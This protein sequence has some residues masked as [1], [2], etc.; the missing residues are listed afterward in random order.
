MWKIQT[1]GVFLNKKAELIHPITGEIDFLYP[2][3]ELLKQL[4][5]NTI[6]LSVSNIFNSKSNSAIINTPS[7]LTFDLDDLCKF[8]KNN[9]FN[10]RLSINMIATYDGYHYNDILNRCKGL[11]ADQIT[12]RKLYESNNNTPE[13]K[14]VRNNQCN[15]KTIYNIKESIKKYGKFLYKLPFGSNV[16]SIQGMSVAIDDDCMGKE[17]L[18]DDNS[19]KLKYVILREDGKLYCQWDDKGSLIF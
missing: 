5:V 9:G 17:N 1:T 16:F 14:W 4:K 10:L 19:F 12:F 6:S 18:N 3:I 11:N 7:N 15:N 8:I 2:N 13:D